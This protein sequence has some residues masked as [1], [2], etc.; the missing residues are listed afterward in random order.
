MDYFRLAPAFCTCEVRSVRFYGLVLREIEETFLG[1]GIPS[2]KGFKTVP[3]KFNAH[4]YRC[5][6]TAAVFSDRL[7]MHPR[8]YEI[9]RFSY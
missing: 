8:H 1:E 9:R 6:L 4:L 2:R 5:S 7:T 3:P